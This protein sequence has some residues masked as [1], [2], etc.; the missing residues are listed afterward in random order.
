MP[1]DDVRILLAQGLELVARR[2]VQIL[3]G[4]L[5]GKLRVPRPIG[6]AQVPPRPLGTIRRAAAVPAGVPAVALSAVTTRE[7]AVPAIAVPTRST[8][9]TLVP[10]L[11]T[12]ALTTRS[13]VTTLV[14]ALTTITLT[15]RRTLAT[16][17]PALT[18]IALTTRRT[19]TTLVPA[20]TTITL[21]TR[22]TV[23]TLVPALTT[24]TLTTRCI[25]P[26]GGIGARTAFVPRRARSLGGSVTV[27]PRSAEPA[28][29]LT[30]DE[31]AVGPLRCVLG[32]RTAVFFF[33]HGAILSRWSF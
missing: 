31:A 22:S 32:R 33:R 2:R 24:I 12:I 20:L 11:T 3:R 23:T 29:G 15:T 14:P 26:G 13:T 19:V 28:S 18:T 4:D 30:V 10:A 21:T 27:I 6:S 25:R 8:V 1:R 17:V 5:V 16:L 7:A 9:T